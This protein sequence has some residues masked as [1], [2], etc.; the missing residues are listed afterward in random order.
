MQRS[1]PRLLSAFDALGCLVLGI[2]TAKDMSVVH[3]VPRVEL[4]G[5]A[6]RK[7]QIDAEPGASMGSGYALA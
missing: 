7:P 6:A 4:I 5:G 1:L 2:V 3:Y